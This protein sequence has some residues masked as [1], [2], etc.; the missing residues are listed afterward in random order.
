MFVIF[1]WISKEWVE[2]VGHTTIS[3]YYSELQSTFDITAFSPFPKIPISKFRGLEP[4]MAALFIWGTTLILAELFT[5]WATSENA[6]PV[7]YIGI[8]YYKLSLYSRSR[9]KAR[10]KR[11]GFPYKSVRLQLGR[12]STREI[13]I[14]DTKVPVSL[15]IDSIL[16]VPSGQF[17]RAADSIRTP[18]TFHLLSY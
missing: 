9:L 17:F 4:R 2:C 3:S 8:F 10:H 18:H 15:V 1:G 5:L 16:A 6:I 13:V 11:K 14:S 7:L 12:A